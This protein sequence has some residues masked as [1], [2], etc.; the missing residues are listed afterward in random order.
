MAST[1]DTGAPAVDMDALIAAANEEGQVNLIALP[2]SWANYQ[3][4]IA[5]FN[6]KYPDI[7][8]PV[9]QPDASSAEELVAV[10]TQRGSDTMPDVLE[11][12]PA[13]CLQAVEEGY[14]DT[15][16]PSRAAEIPESLRDPEGH[17]VSA[18]YGVIAIGV[19]TTL[20]TDFAPTSFADLR[21]APAN[22]VSLNGDPREAGAA[23]AGVM[24]AS[25]ANG[26]SFD[27]IMPGIQYFADLAESGVFNTTQADVSTVLSGETPIVIDW[28]YN[29][30]ALIPQIEEAGFTATVGFPSDA[31]YASYYCQG[32]VA[33]GPNP[34]AARLWIEHLLSDE[35]ALAYLEGGAIPARFPALVENGTITED[36]LTN[37]PP[38]ELLADVSFMND[39]QLEA[40]N[41]ALV[42]NWGPMVLGS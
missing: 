42:E 34:N 15:F 4:V 39:E 32:P 36:M 26:G 1:G 8:T 27:D 3:G 2:P 31:V 21:D 10:D 38:A 11:V 12:S 30:P 33:G 14:F 6:E 37:L 17:W 28:S 35:A 9:Q 25:I 5:S 18:Y 20:V 24:A 19:N 23:F 41:A 29:W 16:T 40:A 13:I 7:Q 22:T